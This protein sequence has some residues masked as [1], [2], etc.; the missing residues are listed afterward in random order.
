MWVKGDDTSQS[1]GFFQLRGASGWA[2]NGISIATYNSGFEVYLKD[3]SNHSFH[4]GGAGTAP[5]N[6]WCHIAL[7][8]DGSN[9]FEIFVQGD[10]VGSVVSNSTALGG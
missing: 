3:G 4:S 2:A 1:K 10:R 5:S 9:K 8:R 6:K 7:T